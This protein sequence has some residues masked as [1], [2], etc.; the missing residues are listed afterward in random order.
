[1]TISRATAQKQMDEKAST[2]PRVIAE[3]ARQ[4]RHVELQW[5]GV[6]EKQGNRPAAERSLLM[7]WAW[8]KKVLEGATK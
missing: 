3:F 4:Q 6:F 5:V 2:D 1:M 7:A 8:H